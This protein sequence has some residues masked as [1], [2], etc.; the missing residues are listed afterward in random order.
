MS[1]TRLRDTPGEVDLRSRL[2]SMGYRGRTEVKVLGRRRADIVF[3][4]AKVAVFVDGCFWHGCPTHGTWPKANAMWWRAKILGNRKRDRNTNR[5]LRKDGWIVLRFW[6][7]SKMD[8]AAIAV[9]KVVDRRLRAK[10]LA[11]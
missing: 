2:R 7:H 10:N 6:E 4:R 5:V 9:A 1:A 11:R 3:A 8:R